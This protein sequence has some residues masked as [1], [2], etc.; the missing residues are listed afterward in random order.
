VPDPEDFMLELYFRP[1]ACS[2]AVRIALLEAGADARYHRVD[3]PTKRTVDGDGD[4][5]AIS[6]KGQ[7]P[8]LRMEDGSLLTENAAVLQYVADRFPAARLAPAAGGPERYR[9]QEWLS[10]IATEIHKLFTYP[11]FMPGTPEPVRAHARAL[12]P[13]A[14]AT[15]AAHLAGRSYL[16]GD[17]FTVADAHL[18]WALTLAR[19]AGVDLAQWPPLATYLDAMYAR[20]SVAKALE[21][22]RALL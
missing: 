11:T 16:V 21:I 1:M 22:E 9:L 4:F 20:P 3:L 14:L 18:V 10:F 6:R 5:L 7:V 2:L 13:H 17:S 8:V 19:F 15:V 12:L